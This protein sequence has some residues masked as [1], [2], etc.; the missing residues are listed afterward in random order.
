M[1]AADDVSRPDDTTAVSRYALCGAAYDPA[2][3]LSFFADTIPSLESFSVVGMT[4]LMVR[5]AS[6]LRNKV[7]VLP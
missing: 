1:S 7:R 3:E 4:T 2:A 5:K 6:T